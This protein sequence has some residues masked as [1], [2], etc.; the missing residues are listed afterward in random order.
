MR[1]I[2][3]LMIPLF[4]LIGCEKSEESNISASLQKNEI[5]SSGED[6]TLDIKSN[7]EWEITVSE[8]W[9][10]P[11]VTEGSGDLFVLLK[12]PRNDSYDN[13][14]CEIIVSSKDKSVFS[15]VNI[16]QKS[17]MGIFLGEDSKTVDVKGG[18]IT[19][20][21]NTNIENIQVST[22]DWIKAI[23][24]KALSK[25][26]YHFNVSQ[27]SKGKRRVG[28]IVFSNSDIK[29]EY[30]VIQNGILPVS[31]SLKEPINY[32][33]G[34][35]TRKIGLVCT[36]ENSDYSMITVSS[37]NEDVCKAYISENMLVL[38]CTGYGKTSLSFS[39]EGKEILKEDICVFDPYISMNVQG[40]SF[41]VGNEIYIE[42]NQEEENY[43]LSS[44][45]NS[46]AKIKDKHHVEIV[47]A[48]KAIIKAKSLINGAESIFEIVAKKIALKAN[49]LN[50]F[51]KGNGYFEVSFIATAE[52]G[53][54]MAYP[55]FLIIN[56]KGAVV[57]FNNGTIITNEYV[58]GYV[59]YK[60][61]T[62][63]VNRENFPNINERLKGYRVSYSCIID[64]ETYNESIP[65]NTMLT[66]EYD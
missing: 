5:S 51:E 59:K 3:F 42:V 52:A 49:I 43:V 26:E 33:E 48:G 57:D 61:I 39:V 25:K 12:I 60:S 28:N 53:S 21:L 50:T 2:L 58:P 6:I 65:I 1:K 19:V 18:D 30:K 38:N 35:E 32:V 41:Y 29:K 31:V 56:E 46:I 44:S 14:E 9:I 47:K 27:N 22:P 24:T 37:S 55:T 45:N 54:K 17:R 34:L 7:C 63:L 64:G 36:P 4:I 8:S 40:G 62:M 11:S 66:G 23:E 15:T 13:R 16:L 10:E 20:E